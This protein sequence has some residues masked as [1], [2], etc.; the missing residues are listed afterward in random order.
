ML[1][2]YV[3]RYWNKFG[4]YNFIE[5]QMHI[6]KNSVI[7]QRLYYIYL[8]SFLSKYMILLW[9][10]LAWKI[11]KSNITYLTCHYYPPNISGLH[12]L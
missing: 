12:L 11:V 1:N 9:I 6:I 5:M 4:C 3:T 8:Y 7:I 10:K 2:I